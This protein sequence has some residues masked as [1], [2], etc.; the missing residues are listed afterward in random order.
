MCY[1]MRW[2]R[3][4]NH[5]FMKYKVIFVQG[6]HKVTLVDGL[7]DVQ[8]CQYAINLHQSSNIAHEVQIFNNDS[9][10]PLLVLIK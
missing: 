4:Y 2:L 1:V 6:E 5:Y 9:S 10:N 3:H 8:A 7:T